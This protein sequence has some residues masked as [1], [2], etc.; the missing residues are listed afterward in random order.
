MSSLFQVLKDLVGW[1]FG[2]CFI[3]L[4]LGLFFNGSIVGGVA[5]L[6]FGFGITPPGRKMATAFNMSSKVSFIALTCLFLVSFGSLADAGSETAPESNLQETVTVTEQSAE[7]DLPEGNTAVAI[8]E[9]ESGEQGD[10][11]I[12]T[13]EETAPTEEIETE[14]PV[15]SEDDEEEVD[16]ELQVHFIDVG[17]GD[18]T[19]VISGEH[20]MLIDAGDDS[21]GTKVQLYLKNQGIEKLD[22]LVLTHTDADH[23]GGADVIISKFDI[24]NVFIG[25]FPKDNTVYRDLMQA[26]QMK[27]LT[28]STPEA[29]ST[30]ALGD[31]FFTTVAPNREYDDANNF[32]I[33]LLLQNG[34]NG[35][36]FTG[37]AEEEA[38]Q[39]ILAAGFDIDCDVLKAGHHGSR[40]SNSKALLSAATPA[41]AVI[42]CETN[43]SYGHPHAEV[44]NNLR[45]MNVQVFRTDE[46]GSVVAV[47][48]GKQITWNCAPSES[49]IAGEPTGSMQEES[50]EENTVTDENGEEEQETDS[51]Q[52][53][54][55]SAGGN[56]AVNDRNGK[57]HIVGECTA[58]GTGDKAMKNP[59]YF[60]TYEEA[61]AYSIQIAP[62]L[63]QE[64]RKCGNC[65]K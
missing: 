61:E 52:T 42:S 18:A 53:S 40:T 59:V 44:L 6:L 34:G 48:D 45:A 32:S 16:T 26:L 15:V 36:L 24:S 4:S 31:A 22:Y 37:D 21:K 39:D 51:G 35:F 56:Y 3:V 11:E 63:E 7:S 46:Q 5:S 25:N 49:W 60:A 23:I 20:A 14:L 2:V 43:N 57:I 29:G 38:E 47:S 33:G 64:K 65:Y 9:E 30:Y 62:E 13:P 55:L 58:T 10:V 12:E 28:Y 54:D 1:F 17:Q 27:G 41:Y 8:A 50:D 19:L